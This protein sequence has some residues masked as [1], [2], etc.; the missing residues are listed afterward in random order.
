M[1]PF[2][3]K[4]AGAS[5]ELSPRERELLEQVREQPQA[6]RKLA[7]SL[8]SQRAITSLKR[9]GL[10]QVGG[11]TPSDAAHVLGLQ[12]NWSVP[13][14]VMA[15]Q[16]GSRLREMK[17]PTPERTD[18]F[19]RDVWSETVRLSA[20]TIL[21]TAFGEHLREDKL[22]HAV[23]AGDGTLGLA[24]ITITP[25]VPV[26][27]VGGP[28][29]V[30]YGEVGRRLGCEVV[31]PEH[32]DVANAVGAAT[33]VVAQTVTVRVDGDGSGIFV[34]HSTVGTKQF[35]DPAAAIEAATALARQS[36]RDAVIAMGAADPQVRVNIRKQLL[37]NAISDS[38]LL[39][40][41]VVAEAIGR[42]NAA[43]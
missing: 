27:A 25:K 20:R 3:A 5:A 43:G 17:F 11:F 26:V 13:A 40:A 16:L 4:Q 6:L 36:A 1:L 18:K 19:A 10:V 37:P 22:I 14:A 30:Y 38:G 29:R 23:C 33:G 7:G 15:A 42:P 34:L 21:D 8:G 12:N 31:F 35:T 41:V 39:E 2:G 24:R 9:K 32:C 28:V